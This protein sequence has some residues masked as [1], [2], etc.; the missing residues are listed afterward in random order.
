MSNDGGYIYFIQCGERVK[1]GFSRS[2]CARFRKMVTDAPAQLK[3][4]W[5]IPGVL[6]EAKRI[7]NSE[8][9]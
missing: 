9:V 4:R 2:L 7:L 5:A 3:R 1:I 8:G 6:N